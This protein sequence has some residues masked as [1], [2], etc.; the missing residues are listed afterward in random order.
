M[1]AV[2]ADISNHKFLVGTNSYK[3]ENEM[4]LL[5]YSEDS[6]RIDQ[7]SVFLIEKGEVWTLS[8]SPY[9]TNVFACGI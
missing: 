2:L 3:K 8:S 5:N 4:H 6:N 1:C 9:D 7:E